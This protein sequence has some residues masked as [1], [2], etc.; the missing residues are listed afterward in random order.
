MFMFYKSCPFPG[1]W[2]EYE[3][4]NSMALWNASGRKDFEAEASSDGND[5]PVSNEPVYKKPT[6]VNITQDQLHLIKIDTQ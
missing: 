3:K 2:E 6:H 5:T 1:S 4:T